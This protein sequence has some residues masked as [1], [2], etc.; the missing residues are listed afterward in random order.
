MK[1][2][3]QLGNPIK[4]WVLF[5]DI[6]NNVTIK[7]KERIDLMDWIKICSDYETFVSFMENKDPNGIVKDGNHTPYTLKVIEFG[8][9]DMLKFLI[10]KGA[11]IN[12]TNVLGLSPIFKSVRDKQYHFADFLIQN[13]VDID[14][15]END[16]KT[17]LMYVI[18]NKD[19]DMFDY[20]IKNG[21]NIHAVN[22]RGHSVL[23]IAYEK[24]WLY[25]AETL[26]Q[27]GAD[28]KHKTNRRRT[29]IDGILRDL[30]YDDHKNKY[31]WVN[32]M[33]KYA[34]KLSDEEHKKIKPYR[35]EQ[36]F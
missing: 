6:K 20:Y 22:N 2:I 7:K 23:H 31:D 25:A 17:E 21:A 3:F 1:I 27:K 13:G 16:G 30:E 29:L 26:I 19:R 8:T 34:D 10:A 11:N 14:N 35:L 12:K 9:I 33:L 15:P 5:F 18:G 4:C 28:T 24:R 32:L 36:I